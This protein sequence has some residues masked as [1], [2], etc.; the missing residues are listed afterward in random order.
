MRIVQNDM[1]S[2]RGLIKVF[3]SHEDKNLFKIAKRQ[4]QDPFAS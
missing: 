2:V 3:L 1:N 4:L